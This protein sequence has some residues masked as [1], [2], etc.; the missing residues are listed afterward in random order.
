VLRDS[1][2]F[3]TFIARVQDEVGR[4]GEGL[5]RGAR[6]HKRSHNED[7]NAQHCALLALQ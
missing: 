1:S 7:E 2:C 3:D 4:G 6:D 5:L